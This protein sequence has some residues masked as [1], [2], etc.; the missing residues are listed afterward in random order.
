MSGTPS[1]VRSP[2]AIPT[3]P[4][5]VA[6]C[7]SDGSG[8]RRGGANVPSPLPAISVTSFV[9]WSA[10]T[11]SARPS[12]VTSAT[13]IFVTPPPVASGTA[14]GKVPSPAP[15]STV[16]PP[17]RLPTTR[18]SRPSPSTSPT[19]SAWG[20][21]V[22]EDEAPVR[23]GKEPR[24]LPS[25]TATRS[26]AFWATARSRRP[27]PLKSPIA[28][29]RGPAETR[30]EFACLNPPSPSPRS[31]VTRPAKL[32]VTSASGIRSPL[33]SATISSSVPAGTARGSGAPK[34]GSVRATALADQAR[35]SP[36]APAAARILRRTGRMPPRS[37]PRWSRGRLRGGAAPTPRWSPRP[38]PRRR[39]RHPPRRPCA[40]ARPGRA[41]AARR[42][43]ARPGAGPRWPRPLPPDVHRGRDR[44]ERDQPAVADVLQREEEDGQREQ[45]HREDG[46]ERLGQPVRAQRPAPL[47]RSHP[48]PRPVAGAHVAALVRLTLTPPD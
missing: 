19:A 8:R 26:A 5:A 29:A 10:V 31:V 27:S 41:P 35:A 21:S 33:T 36:A 42:Q 43:G 1:P 4:A 39:G 48:P 40:R 23:A 6:Y 12:P 13:T 37:R 30:N 32:L 3:G 14:V 11:T 44:Q 47:R 45:E 17:S 34:R 20:W 15:R 46:P 25:S 24:P 16:T 9:V 28:S 38:A 2:T 7:P 18:S 22:V